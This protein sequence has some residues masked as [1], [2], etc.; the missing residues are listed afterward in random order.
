MVDSLRIQEAGRSIDQPTALITVLASGKCSSHSGFSLA[1]S[2]SSLIQETL[3]RDAGAIYSWTDSRLIAET[4]IGPH[5]ASKPPS[6]NGSGFR[7]RARGGLPSFVLANSSD[8]HGP[9][10]RACLPDQL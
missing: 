1:M 3:T 5:N 8:V 4:G 2:G 9:H 7:G 6:G 10:H